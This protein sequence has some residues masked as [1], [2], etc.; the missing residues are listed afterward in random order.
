MSDQGES[1]GFN[2][3]S[4]GRRSNSPESP[5][6]EVKVKIGKKA[7]QGDEIY[8]LSPGLKRGKVLIVNFKHYEST[9]FKTREGSQRDVENLDSLFSQLGKVFILPLFK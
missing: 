1:D 5:G 6:L 8:K 3:F 7:F 4:S 2:C 9:E